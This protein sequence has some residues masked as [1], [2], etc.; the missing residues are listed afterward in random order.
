[1]KAKIPENNTLKDL[2][3][4]LAETVHKPIDISKLIGMD[5][6][7]KQ[8]LML[9][10]AGMDEAFYGGP[11]KP[12]ACPWLGWGGA[13][14]PG[15]TTA[16]MMTLITAAYHIP[17]IQTALFRR[18]FPELEGADGAIAM[19]ASMLRS[20]DA[21]YNSGKHVWTFKN[22]SKIHFCHLNE[23][24]DKYKYQSSQFGII[25]IDESTHMP[26]DYIE[27]LTTRLRSAVTW[28]GYSQSFPFIVQSSNPGNIGHLAFKKL[29]ADNP[30]YVVNEVNAPGSTDIKLR[31][32]FIPSKLT[33]NKILMSKDPD[34]EKKLD[35]LN[36]TLKA[37]LKD[38]RWDVMG[39]LFFSNHFNPEEVVKDIEPQDDW[40]YYGSIDYG[41]HSRNDTDKPFI[42]L[43]C[44]T[45]RQGNAYI[46]D[47]IA[48]GGTDPSQQIVA[49]KEMEERYARNIVYRVGCRGMFIRKSL[50]LTQPSIDEQYRNN[51]VPVVRT[52]VNSVAAAEMLIIRYLVEKRLTIS[53][54]CRKLIEQLVNIP[55]SERDPEVTDDN[56][57]D[58][59]IETLYDFLSSR[60]SKAPEPPKKLTGEL[61]SIAELIDWEEERYSHLI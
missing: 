32:I 59:A 17:G 38:G 21:I 19:S 40:Q 61:P 37:M 30:P 46:I 10:S 16:D 57:E 43:L 44:A 15:K 33:D 3:D 53:P 29:F 12:P 24:K 13:A 18:T 2:L 26:W 36:P 47:E 11:V 51:G 41:F 49:I 39:G 34:Y 7:D 52:T 42:Y 54:R 6:Q 50:D 14:G 4:S 22:G 27:Y 56:A 28:P 55:V 9:K 31:T 60:P 8:R 48:Q 23:A 58:H 5:L 1:M 25:I 20:S 35:A 45:D